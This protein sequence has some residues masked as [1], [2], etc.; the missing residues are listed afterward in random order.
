MERDSLC[1]QSKNWEAVMQNQRESVGFRKAI[2]VNPCPI[3]SG[4]SFFS[5]G[6]MSSTTI[7]ERQSIR[8][9]DSVLGIA[10]FLRQPLPSLSPPLRPSLLGSEHGYL[11][12]FAIFL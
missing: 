2:A 8:W 7:I 3:A 9:I 10:F 11:P 12:T 1:N 5:S 4:L 6:E